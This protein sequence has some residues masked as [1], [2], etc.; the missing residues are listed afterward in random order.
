MANKEKMNADAGELKDDKDKVKNPEA[1]EIEAGNGKAEGA[2]K[3]DDTDKVDEA[4]TD[5]EETPKED[6][7]ADDDMANK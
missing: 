5:A 1:E 3:A 7:S 6:K 4:N 2:D